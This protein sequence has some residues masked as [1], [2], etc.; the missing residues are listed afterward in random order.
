MDQE[1][2]ENFNSFSFEL[3]KGFENLMDLTLNFLSDSN[4]TFNDTILA[5]IDLYLPKLQYL[6]R[7]DTDIDTQWTEY[8]KNKP[9]DKS[10]RI[11]RYFYI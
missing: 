5:D 6:S 7:D 2:E 9:I 4:V 8:V 3:F 1:Y 11:K 10:K